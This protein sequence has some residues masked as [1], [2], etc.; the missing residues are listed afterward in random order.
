MRASQGTPFAFF[1][2]TSCDIDSHFGPHN[3]IINLTLCKDPTSRS[4]CILTMVRSQVET[5][6]V[7]YSALT[8]AR[9]TVSVRMIWR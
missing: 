4:I 3:I 1:P 5:G 2:S 7:P 9:V 8:V 6:R